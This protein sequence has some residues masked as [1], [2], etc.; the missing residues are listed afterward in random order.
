MKLLFHLIILIFSCFKLNAWNAPSISSPSNNAEVW[1]GVRLNWNSVV[2]SQRYEVQVDTSLQF[3]SPLLYSATNTYINSSSGNVDTQVDPPSLRFGTQYYWRVRAYVPGD[4]SSWNNSTFITR[5]FVNISSP[6][7]G[8]EV[9]T[10]FTLN[11]DAH[12]GVNFYDVRVDTSLN[13]NTDALRTVSNTYINTSDGNNDTQWFINNLY[14][15][16][17]Y[18]WQIRARNSAD[19]SEW[20]SPRTF[21]TR[22]FVTIASPSNEA[23]VWT[24][25][26][27]NWNAHDGVSFYDVR[28]DTSLNFNTDALRTVSNTYINT[29]DGNNDTQW[30]IDNLYFGHT[31]YWQVRARNAVDSS[32][33]SEPLTFQTRDFVNKTSP[34]NTDT[35]TGL[36]INWAPHAGVDFYDMQVDTSSQ[37]N[38]NELNTYTRSYI[39]STDGNNDTQVFVEDL[40]FG[41]RYYWRVRA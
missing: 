7:D 41:I 25:L 2:G 1:V 10:G 13:F 40:L 30:F 29:S 14:F 18:Y 27:L 12:D 34:N 31:Y 28:V 21:Q 6:S 24:G 3:N 9:W 35:W 20:T 37:F 15:G 8:A 11:W 26:T 16:S 32:T 22:D 36:T 5:D 33:W 38:S 17:V 19:S 23:D 4:T 39:N